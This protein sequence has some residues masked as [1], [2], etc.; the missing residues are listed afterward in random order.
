MILKLY[1]NRMKT[2]IK[3]YQVSETLGAFNIA[4]LLC[5]HSAYVI[6]FDHIN[7]HPPYLEIAISAFCSAIFEALC[8]ALIADSILSLNLADRMRKR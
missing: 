7:R 8:A 2:K 1:L 5:Y 6:A 3:L 4:F